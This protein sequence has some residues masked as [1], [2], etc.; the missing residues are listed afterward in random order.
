MILKK[1]IQKILVI[2][3]SNIGDL[4]MTFPVID[5][6]RR[7]FPAAKLDLVVGPKCEGLVRGNPHINR[8]YVYDKKASGPVLLRWII[9]LFKERYDLAVDLRNTAIPFLIFAK[10]K[11]P[12]MIRRPVVSHMREQHLK[13]LGCVHRF[14]SESNDHQ[15]LHFADRDWQ[16]VNALLT[17]SGLAGKKYVVLAPGSRAEKKRWREDG[18]AQVADE[19]IRKY[20][21]PVI[22]AG[23][24]GDREIIERIRAMMK[25]TAFDFSGQLNLVQFGCLIAKARLAITNDSASMHL[26][27]YLGVPVLTIF[28]PT[29]PTTCG[30]WSKMNFS[31]RKH[32]LCPACAGKR[33]VPHE[34]IQAVTPEDVLSALEPQAKELFNGE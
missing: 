30:P 8:I 22:F 28:G 12:V 15:A 6:L 3:L 9:E 25:E 16:T 4:I 11:T 17:Q 5:I 32:E 20:Q 13:R 2:S 21:A 31:V 24:E 27:S 33:D 14:A 10:Y 29:D 23:D 34:C 26:A 7:D 18:F 1:R 19:L